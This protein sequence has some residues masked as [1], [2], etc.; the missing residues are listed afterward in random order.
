[1]LDESPD[2]VDV[3][4]GGVVAGWVCTRIHT[5]DSMGEIYVI[6]VAPEY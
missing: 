4:L 3:A 1:M 6:A 5:E 2:S